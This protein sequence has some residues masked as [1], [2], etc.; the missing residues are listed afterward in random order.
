[1]NRPVFFFYQPELFTSTQVE[2]ILLTSYHQPHQFIKYLL[3]ISESKADNN[4]TKVM[5]WKKKTK[6]WQ[7]SKSLDIKSFNIEKK[8]MFI[9][10]NSPFYL[11]FSFLL[12]S[13]QQ[14]R[15]LCEY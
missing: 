6:E 3:V 9:T 7:V 1:M 10:R 11:I 4:K 15:K 5:R 13:E 8:N 2:I 14:D 12:S